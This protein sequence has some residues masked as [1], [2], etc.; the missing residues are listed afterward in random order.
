MSI[1]PEQVVAAYRSSGLRARRHMLYSP[2]DNCACGLGAIL[3]CTY[4]PE[5]EQKYNISDT[6]IVCN[7]LGVNHQYG[8][9]FMAG[10]DST[11]ILHPKTEGYADGQRAWRACV[12]E[13]IIVP[14]GRRF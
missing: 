6:T 14:Y 12:L 1:T 2:K 13:N 4:G 7:L 5:L 9:E 8:L 10:F 3:Y 11:T